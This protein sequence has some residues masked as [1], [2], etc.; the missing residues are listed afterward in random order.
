MKMRLTQFSKVKVPKMPS[1]PPPKVSSRSSKN[2]LDP[3][4]RVH[5]KKVALAKL[6]PYTRAMKVVASKD[7]SIEYAHIYTNDKVNQEHDLSLKVLG[8]L[9]KEFRE[10]NKS[11]SLVVM[12]DDYSF[13]DPSFD[14]DEFVGWLREKSFSQDVLFRESQLI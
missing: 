11:Y 6:Q 3:L 7:I 13:P 5:H 12:V 2:T 9:E 10:Q 14:Y 4:L 8:E 1:T